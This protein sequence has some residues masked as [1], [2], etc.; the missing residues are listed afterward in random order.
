VDAR[1]PSGV[2]RSRVCTLGT[3]FSR[4]QR[5][6]SRKTGS[7]RRTTR[8]VFAVVF[9]AGAAVV[10][11]G[12]LALGGLYIYNRIETPKQNATQPDYDGLAAKYGGTSS[13]RRTRPLSSGYCALGFS[14]A[15]VYCMVRIAR[16]VETEVSTPVKTVLVSAYPEDR[17][18]AQSGCGAGVPR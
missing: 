16:R 7:Y 5:R 14:L 11:L 18:A 6:I 4:S 9:G 13:D 17:A 1:L 10:V 2:G 3:K 15:S 12:Y 8:K